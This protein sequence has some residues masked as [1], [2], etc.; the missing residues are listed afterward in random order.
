M[1]QMWSYIGTEMDYQYMYHYLVYGWA[2][3]HVH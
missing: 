2:K 1:L 3:G